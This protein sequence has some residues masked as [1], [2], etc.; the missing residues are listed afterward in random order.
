MNWIHLGQD[1]FCHSSFLCEHGNDSQSSI[2]G[3]QFYPS[4]AVVA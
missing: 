4:V 2:N 3:S 1:G